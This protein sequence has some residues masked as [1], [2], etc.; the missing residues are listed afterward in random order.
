MRLPDGYS[1]CRIDPRARA[2]EIGVAAV[3]RDGSGDASPA[4]V[5]IGTL[6]DGTVY[7]GCLVDG[8]GRVIE[9]F[10]LLVQSA[11]AAMA[12]PGSE[13]AG[14]TGA[15]LDLRWKRLGESV[16]A[17]DDRALIA[18]Q[19]EA[20]RG[21]PVWLDPARALAVTPSDGEAGWRLCR[22]DSLLAAHGLMPYSTSLARYL[23]KSRA[24]EAIT[25]E[26]GFV[27]ATPGAPGTD[28]QAK[29]LCPELLP[30][31]PEG[32]DVLC[33]RHVPG[34]FESYADFLGLG[35]FGDQQPVRSIVG[36]DGRA[37][38]G[39]TLGD[40]VFD[41][42]ALF[43]GR[44]GR[45]G[46]LL[47]VYHLKL[48]LLAGAIDAVR[49]AVDRLDRPL[50][51]LDASSF[52]VSVAA[53][54]VSVPKWWTA[55]VSLVDPG[56]AVELA[57][58]THGARLFA[59][60]GRSASV[61]TP[62]M[63]AALSGTA[64]VRIRTV[65]T[66]PTDGTRISG[67]LSTQEPLSRTVSSLLWL[68]LR[69]GTDPLSV[70]AKPVDEPGLAPGE[71]RFESLPMDLGDQE[72]Q[73]RALAGVPQPGTAFEVLPVLSTPCDLYAL[74][75]LALRT[76]C[77]D[78]TQPLAVALDEAMAL[79]RVLADAVGGG[80]A[81]E[82]VLGVVASDARWAESLGPQ[83]LAAGGLTADE[84]FDLI[85][86]E[87]WWRT[88]ALIVRMF[89]GLGPDSFCRDL[90]DSPASGLSTVFGGPAQELRTL[91]VRSR[92]LIVLDWRLNREIH[93]VLQSV[94]P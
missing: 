28:R 62:A 3:L 21:E 5:R 53:G 77:V 49:R 45:G 44:H 39:R 18:F 63:G 11:A 7:L 17:G 85:P 54:D 93:A 84:A 76:L 23:V 36:L 25:D 94:A 15:V 2:G 61:Y 9:W 35:R 19:A 74:A 59:S 64:E 20:S 55:R 47:E 24:G 30:F 80:S 56:D 70:Y 32:G 79:G 82:R 52:A 42:A 71:V 92:S 72:A 81:H 89:P 88:I 50:L 12:A 38:K 1:F 73:V 58:G 67:T 37:L 6:I 48:Q 65:E 87:M 8:E 57:T 10:E 13:L 69:L 91:L 33:R 43:M 75:V 66:D 26:P 90:G 83:R 14:L 68:G 40:G 41:D 16:A 22:D 31:N 4:L 60:V 34:D 29:D 51:R 78:E 27:A 86:P 46:R